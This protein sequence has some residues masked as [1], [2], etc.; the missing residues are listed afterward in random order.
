MNKLFFVPALLLVLMHMVS[1]SD[2]DTP[3]DQE[4]EIPVTFKVST[5]NV[6][7]QPM[8]K[9]AISGAPL[10]EVVNAIGYYIYS[11]SEPVGGINYLIR[12]FKISCT[13]S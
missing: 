10:D 11:T 8:T 1:C 9:S 7:V 6:D 5:L 3:E 13:Y 4:K 2:Q 12:C